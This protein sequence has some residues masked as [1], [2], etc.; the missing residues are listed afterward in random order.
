M[1]PTPIL[2]ETELIQEKSYLDV[3]F[4]KPVGEIF[5]NFCNSVF[6]KISTE[7]LTC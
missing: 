2:R 1:T 5:R 3:W 6:Y 7:V 4:D